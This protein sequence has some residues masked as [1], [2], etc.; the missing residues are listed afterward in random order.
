MTGESLNVYHQLNTFV[1]QVE[2]WQKS[3]KIL[4]TQ[5]DM[6]NRISYDD[7]KKLLNQDICESIPTK[8]K[9]YFYIYI[10]S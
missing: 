2:E 4:K 9:V 5:M 1:Q 6:G 7:L 8:Q 3:A 10:I